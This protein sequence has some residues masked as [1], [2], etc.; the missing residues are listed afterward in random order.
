[1]EEGSGYIIETQSNPAPAPPPAPPPPKIIINQLYDNSLWVLE[2]KRVFLYFSARQLSS[3]REAQTLSNDSSEPMLQSHGLQLPIRWTLLLWWVSHKMRYR[4]RL[5]SSDTEW[6]RYKCLVFEKLSLFQAFGHQFKRSAMVNGAF[7]AVERRQRKVWVFFASLL[8]SHCMLVH[9]TFLTERLE[10]PTGSFVFF[11]NV[12]ICFLAL[13]VLFYV[14]YFLLLLFCF[15]C[16]CC[17]GHSLSLFGCLEL[18]SK[19]V[20][21]NRWPVSVLNLCNW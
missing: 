14:V 3:A 19:C 7:V 20:K 18:P 10:Q 8:P 11:L 5:P 2:S 6:V 9:S 1:M 21:S 13:C 16:F 12:F 4:W 15:V 17:F